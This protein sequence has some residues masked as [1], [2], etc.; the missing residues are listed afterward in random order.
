MSAISEPAAVGTA[1]D[2]DR[3]AT[4]MGTHVAGFAGPITLDKFSGGQSNPTF[5]LDTATKRYVL[6]RKPAGALLASAHAVDREYRLLSALH[7]EGFPVP[8]PIALCEDET[9]IGSAF[10]VMERVDGRTFWDGKLP[11]HEPTERREIY[12]QMVATLAR[13]HRFDPA[14]VGLTDYGRPGNYFGRQV[15]RWSRQYRAAQTEDVPEVEKLMDWLSRTVPEQSSAT[16]IHG[17]YRLDNLIFDPSGGKVASVIDWELSTIGDPLADFS[18]FAV[19]WIMPADGLAALGEVDLAPLGIPSLEDI[20]DLYCALS[21]RPRVANP[22]WYFA[23]NLFRIVGIVQG[24][25]KRIIDGTASSLEAE[26]SAAK[27]VPMA[28]LGWEQARI[29]GAPNL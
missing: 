17:D 5:A 2:L 1:I 9:V 16:I 21:E 10:Y 26:R 7:P 28:R 11:D 13:L 22:H 19:H 8:R 6:R 23:F 20:T 4:W 18:Y 12:E 24:I 14:Q 3:L 27:L 29:A 15:A 25:R